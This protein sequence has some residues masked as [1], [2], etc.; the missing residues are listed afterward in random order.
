MDSDIHMALS[1]LEGC[2]GWLTAVVF[3]VVGL[4]PVRKA[5]ATSGFLIAGG[6]ALRWLFFCCQSLPMTLYQ[7]DQY[8]LADTLGSLPSLGAMLMWLLSSAC[9]VAGFAT[10]ARH[11]TAST[12]MSQAGA[13][14]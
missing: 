4:V 1:S 13:S 10:L 7:A 11:V 3:L 14:S 8:E 9:I 6:G 12:A 2:I 5:H